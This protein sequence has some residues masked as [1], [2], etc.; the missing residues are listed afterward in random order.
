VSY[1]SK[2]SSR[3][4]T[5][6]TGRSIRG[7]LEAQVVS[8][9]LIS[10]PHTNMIGFYYLPLTYI[11]NDTGI[12][13]EGCSKALR[14]LCEEG[15]CQYD[16]ASEVVWVVEMARIQIGAALKPD[17]NRVI[18]IEREYEALPNNAYLKQFFQTY[19]KPYH[20]KKARA[21]KGPSKPITVTVAV[22]VAASTTAALATTPAAE[23][24]APAAARQARPRKEITESKTKT[25]WDAYVE[26][27]SRRYNTVPVRNARTNSQ[28][29]Q[30]VDRV[31]AVEAP[32]IAAFYVR[33]N[34]AFYVSRQHAVGIL[35]ADA[36]G[37][38]T[39]WMNGTAITET[40]A[41]QTDRKQNNLGIAEKLIAESRA[42]NASK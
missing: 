34:K 35:L 7:Y 11:S 20:L 37:L 1:Y 42:A 12:P 2:V 40:E 33:H 9:Y 19:G 8:M 39:Q 23:G 29:A 24:H 27:Y 10:N 14:R 13:I 16:E 31:G 3:F 22:A 28:M 17:D 32:S 6:S 38:R 26:A 41:R 25:T 18:G 4:W 5:G 30:F 36:E 15:F 21:Y